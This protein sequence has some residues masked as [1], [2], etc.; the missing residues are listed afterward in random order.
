MLQQQWKQHNVYKNGHIYVIGSTTSLH[1]R[2]MFPWT[3][4][5]N[6]A[7]EIEKKGERTRNKIKN[8]QKMWHCFILV[9]LC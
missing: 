6:K 4:R 7:N 5:E 1:G 8:K 3:Y 2:R 9:S